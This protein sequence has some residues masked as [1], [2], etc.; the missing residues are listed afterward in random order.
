MIVGAGPIEAELHVHAKQ[1]GLTNVHFL[2]SLSE[3]D[4]V[5]LFKLSYAVVFPSHLRSE[6][7][8]ISLLEGAMFGKPLISSEIGTGTSFVNI[9]GETGIV[10]RP[11]DPDDLREALRSLYENPELAERMGRQAYLRYQTYFTA[12]R[13]VDSYMGL[14]EE[15]L[16]ARKHR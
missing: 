10:V 1:A 15:L 6:A 2:G 14:Y 8:G 3:S 12:D 11:E 9:H 16:S 4:K 5:A 7:F 13:M